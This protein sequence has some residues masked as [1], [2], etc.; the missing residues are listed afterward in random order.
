M[1]DSISVR[2]S[3]D[4]YDFAHSSAK[5]TQVYVQIPDVARASYLLDA[6]MYLEL[7]DKEWAAVLDAAHDEFVR[8]GT[9]SDPASAAARQTIREWLSID[10]NHDAVNEAWF[11]DR[12]R[13]DPVSRS[14]LGDVERLRAQVV[15]LEEQRER[16]RGRLVA[17]QN[18]ALN[19]RGALSPM[20]ED[21]KVPFPLE[22]TLTPA[23]D[24]LIARVAE[25]E[26]DLAAKAQDAAA[27]VKGWGRSRGR[28]AELEGLLSESM[29]QVA[30]ADAALNAVETVPF[31][32]GDVDRAAD[33]LTRLFAPTQ[34]LREDEA[35]EAPYVSHPLPPHDA[36]CAR[37]G[38]GHRGEAHHHEGATCWAHLPK[39]AV[40]PLN[41]C[42]C[43]EFLPESGGV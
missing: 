24:W 8:R 19:M 27:A 23:V 5:Q 2:I 9:V 13:R 33:K 40:E 26:A 28:V 39:Q 21:R 32:L 30:A 17:L 25:L 6:D 3:L 15:E 16:R 7:K 42:K 34:S 14:L 31:S 1:S 35:A 38:C 11:Q 20:G 37:P 41:I 36:V 43:D 18:D 22:D 4:S 12:A 10:E 29:G